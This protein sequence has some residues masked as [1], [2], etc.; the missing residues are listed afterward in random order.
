[1]FQWVIFADQQFWRHFFLYQA[2]LMSWDQFKVGVLI[3]VLLLGAPLLLAYDFLRT[4]PDRLMKCYFLC[5]VV[6]GIAT[7]GKES[8]FIQYFYESILL[9]SA[10]IP[11]LLALRLAKGTVPVDLILLL[12]IALVAGQWYTPPSPAPADFSEN[13]KWQSFLKGQVPVGTRALGFRGGDLI[14]AGFDTPFADLFQT[15]LMARRGIVPDDRLIARIE[16]RWFRVIVLDVDLANE[17]DDLRLNYYLTERARQVI[18]RRY[19]VV[20]THPQPRPERMSDPGL[21][22]VYVP[23]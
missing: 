15:E 7:I 11:A 2:T 12:T 13:A 23:R 14:Q 9:I 10:A 20:A 4:R 16:E 21:F 6:L 18:S 8:A 1:M 22:F 17:R 3:F 5:A 19:R